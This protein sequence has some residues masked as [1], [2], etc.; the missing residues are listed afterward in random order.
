[1][2]NFYH[3]FIEPKEGVTPQQVEDKMNLA[4]DWFRCTRNVWVLYTTSDHDKWQERLRPLVDPKGSLFICRL[5]VNERNGWM[6]RTF[7]DWL[8]KPRS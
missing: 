5:D 4:V 1:M 3:V 2:G 8:N 7:W 6:I